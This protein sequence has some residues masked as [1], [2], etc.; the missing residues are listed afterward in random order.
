M[1]ATA[2]DIVNATRAFFAHRAIIPYIQR[3]MEGYDSQSGMWMKPPVIS[4]DDTV[5]D[6]SEIDDSIY[7]VY[8]DQADAFYDILQEALGVEEMTKQLTNIYTLRYASIL[9]HCFNLL[10]QSRRYLHHHFT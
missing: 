8:V 4:H 10:T 6:R 5:T 7:K 2:E 9:R 1:K 3:I